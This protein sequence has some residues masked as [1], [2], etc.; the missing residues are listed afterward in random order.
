MLVTSLNLFL[1]TYIHPGHVGFVLGR[2]AADQ[3][4]RCCFL[5][6]MK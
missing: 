6:P 1:A 5:N 3:T 4:Y 2:Q